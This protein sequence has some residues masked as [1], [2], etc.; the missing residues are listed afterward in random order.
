MTTYRKLLLANL[1]DEQKILGLPYPR[2][3]TWLIFL[4]TT[5]FVSEEKFESRMI[6]RKERLA[7]TRGYKTLC[8]V[9]GK[10]KG[11]P[12]EMIKVISNG[13]LALCEQSWHKRYEYRSLFRKQQKAMEEIKKRIDAIVSGSIHFALDLPALS[14]EDCRL[15]TPFREKVVSW[16]FLEAYNCLP[17]E[18]KKDIQPP[19]QTRLPVEQIPQSPPR[20]PDTFLATKSLKKATALI[21]SPGAPL[22]PAARTKK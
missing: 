2:W 3:L 4:L 18:M 19:R 6:R 21:P 5:R 13:L 22:V 12:E 8:R 16:H 10:D 7:A 1:K 20:P 9:V 17:K 11:S 14:H 15:G